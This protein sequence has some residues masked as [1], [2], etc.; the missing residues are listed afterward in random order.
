[1]E[2]H[3]STQGRAWAEVW[4][5]KETARPKK[6]ARVALELGE[7]VTGDPMSCKSPGA[8]P[9]QGSEDSRQIWALQ[10]PSAHTWNSLQGFEAV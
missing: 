9:K 6:V 3:S 7:K 2:K 4:K 8:Y 5:E 10:S 1:M